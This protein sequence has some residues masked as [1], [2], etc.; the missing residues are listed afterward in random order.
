[1]IIGA[2]CSLYIFHGFASD[3]L[4][5]LEEISVNS[6]YGHIQIAKPSYFD[7]TPLRLARDGYLTEVENLRAEIEKNPHVSSVAGRLSFFTLLSKGESSISARGIGFEVDK[8]ENI[9]SAMQIVKGAQLQ[10][11]SDREILIGQGLNGSMHANIGDNITLVTSTLDGTVNA[12]DVTVRGIFNMGVAEIDDYVF[13]IPH[14]AAQR[15]LDADSFEQLIIQIKP[16]S[17]LQKVIQELQPLADQHNL[18]VK[19]WRE[20]STLFNQVEDFWEMQIRIV[21]YLLGIMIFLGIANTI[22]M[23]IIERT[24]EIGTL[25]ALGFEKKDLMVIFLL[26]SLIMGLVGVGIAFPCAVLISTLLNMAQI[27]I[28]LPGSSVEFPFQILFTYSGLVQG[29]I[30]ALVIPVLATLPALRHILKK[31]IVD[32]LR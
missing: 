1:M 22:S 10:P 16:D 5:S 28:V 20:L 6:M 32:S 23:S 24:S 26:E 14:K 7:R 12:M 18:K 2:F 13:F 19:S 27:P 8:E 31:S 3:I 29:A 11:S 25:R 30:V 4:Q 15:L 17:S 21:V 9:W